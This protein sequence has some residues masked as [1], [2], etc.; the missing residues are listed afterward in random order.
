MDNEANSLIE[1]P[2]RGRTDGVPISPPHS[3]HDRSFAL[4]NHHCTRSSCGFASAAACASGSVA[5]SQRDQRS[6]GELDA[7]RSPYSPVVSS[8]ELLS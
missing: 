3:E 1:R 2:M 8:L 5:P 4:L 7:S 6:W